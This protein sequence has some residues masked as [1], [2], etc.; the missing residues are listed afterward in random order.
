MLGSFF[1]WRSVFVGGGEPGFHFLSLISVLDTIAVF[2]KEL[3][4]NL[5]LFCLH[6]SFLDTINIVLLAGNYERNRH[7]PSRRFC[8]LYW[9]SFLE[10]PG[11]FY[12]LTPAKIRV[13]SV[14]Y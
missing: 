12:S 10:L 7:N 5:G 6:F 4:V 2:I 11:K 9:L 14:A 3:S 13:I 8:Q 1:P